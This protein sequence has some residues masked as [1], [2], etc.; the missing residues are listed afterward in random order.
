MT[1]FHLLCLM[2]LLYGFFAFF[3]LMESKFSMAGAVI[4]ATFGCFF[5]LLVVATDDL[6]V[7]INPREYLV[8]AAHP[9][10]DR[11]VMLAKLWVVGSSLVQLSALLFLPSAAG[12]VVST[13][14]PV[15]AAAYFVGASAAALATSIAAIF[16]ATAVV[17]LGGRSAMDRVLPWVQVTFQL[18][19]VLLIG[20]RHALAWMKASSLPAGV[21]WTLPTVWFLAGYEAL[22]YGLSPG[23]AVRGA[24][25][26]VLLTGLVVGGARFLGARMGEKLLEPLER[27]RV[28][29]PANDPTVRKRTDASGG[30]LQGEKK[31]LFRLLRVHLRTDWRTRSEFLM[32][33]IVLLYFLFQIWREP[34]IGAGGAAVLL[35][36]VGWFLMLSLDVLTRSS[37]P[38]VL[39]CVLVSPVDRTRLAMSSIALVRLFQLLPVGV[40]LLVFEILRGSGSAVERLLRVTEVVLFGDLLL[41]TG[42]G[43]FPDFPFSRPTR[44]EG[45]AGG[46]RFVTMFLGGLIAAA[47]SAVIT[48][49]SLLGVPGLAAGIALALLLRF[50]ISAWTKLRVTRAAEQLELA[51]E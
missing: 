34:S 17:A 7:L 4:S 6:D 19:Y 35:T 3:I 47:G 30:V 16:L 5:I 9:H 45:Q 21:V 41:L 40:L 20:G 27:P 13:N 28:R 48:L 12:I 18:S 23:L 11:S 29:R 46:R 8:L 25:A 24:G 33:P 10:D 22:R 31:W 42:R 38:Q 14:S 39:W 44:S 15:V 37:R 49:L 50:P 43:L 26:L 36:F 1:P 51:A 32:T 2:A